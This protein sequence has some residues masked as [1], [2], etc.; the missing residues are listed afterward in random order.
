MAG[1]MQQVAGMSKF[2]QMRA[3]SQM[4]QSG[5]FTNPN[6]QLAAPKMRSKRGPL[7]TRAEEEKKKRKKKEA[8]KQ[9]KKNRK[10]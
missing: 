2:Q 10:R 3:I 7:D 5:L 1:V 4:G 6:A 9:R 8:A